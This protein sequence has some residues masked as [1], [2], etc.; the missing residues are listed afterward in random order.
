MPE[1]V[2]DTPC[3]YC[4]SRPLTTVRRVPYYRGYVLVFQH[5]SKRFAG[6]VSC[7]RKQMLLESAKAVGFGWFSPKALVATVFV[8][9]VTFGRAFFVRSDPKRVTA[10]LDEIGVPTNTHEVRL[11]DALYSSAAAIIKSDGE[12]HPSEVDIAA[13]YLQV[14]LPEFE[15][16]ALNDRVAEWKG[17]M[18]VDAHALFL[19]RFLKPEG[20]QVILE[21]FAAVILADG[22]IEKQERKQWDRVAKVFGLSKT[23]IQE[24]WASLVEGESVPV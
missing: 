11:A 2:T 22:K 8:T 4:K 18:S 9:P 17:G 24:K 7:V 12:A 19:R 20:Q 14:L 5:G 6:C 23:E 10:L 1:Q 3:P 21:M 15:R 13:E 16:S